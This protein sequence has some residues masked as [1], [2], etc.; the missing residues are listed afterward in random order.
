MECVMG[1]AKQ[2]AYPLAG[3]L[4]PGSDFFASLTTAQGRF[5]FAWA[6]V[7]SDI[8]LEKSNQWLVNIP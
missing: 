4:V 6:T 1:K 3:R 8:T 2:F 5:F 7:K